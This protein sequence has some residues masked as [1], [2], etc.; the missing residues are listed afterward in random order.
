MNPMLKKLTVMFDAPDSP[1]PAAY[2]EEL[3]EML[4]PYSDHVLTV[5]SK[6][7]GRRGGRSFPSP[8][9]IMKAVEEVM[10]LQPRQQAESSNQYSRNLLAPPTYEELTRNRLAK[11]WR[12][13]VC[14]KYGSVDDYL[15]QTVNIRSDGAGGAYMA[16]KKSTFSQMKNTEFGGK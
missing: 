10:G 6:L 9:D 8:K 16:S 12:D 11:E 7:V 15:R 4:R 13:K 14:A 2:L 1:D 5:A 3:E